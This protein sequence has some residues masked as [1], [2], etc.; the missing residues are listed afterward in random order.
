MV[1]HT[2]GVLINVDQDVEEDWP[3]TIED[4]SCRDYDVLLRPGEMLLYEGTRLQHS[5]PYPLRGSRYANLFCHFTP[6]EAVLTF[7]GVQ[8]LNGSTATFQ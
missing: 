6:N 4:H 7:D 5:R 2:I 3:L 1:T 8:D